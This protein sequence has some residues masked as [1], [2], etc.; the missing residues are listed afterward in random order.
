MICIGLHGV[1]VGG[2][3]QGNAQDDGMV[4][5][6]LLKSQFHTAIDRHSLLPLLLLLSHSFSLSLSG[7][8]HPVLS[9]D[10]VR[11]PSVFGGPSFWRPSTP[12]L[13]Q[14]PPHWR[15]GSRRVA[16]SSGSGKKEDY[17]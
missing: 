7:V 10:E 1:L 8:G 4:V 2:P 6:I 14:P 12:K 9:E 13:P 11:R 15:L 5:I 16:E 3:V 17:S